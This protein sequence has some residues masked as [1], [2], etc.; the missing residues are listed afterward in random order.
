MLLSIKSS[1]QDLGYILAKNPN[2]LPIAKNE[3]NGLLFGFFDNRPDI[4]R[5][6]YLEQETLRDDGYL[7][8]EKYV[9]PRLA[10]AIFSKILNS[11][12]SKDMLQ[13][14]DHQ[15]Y[16]QLNY[17]K[18]PKYLI[19]S[20]SAA[21][22]TFEA[23]EKT[24]NVYS[25]IFSSH[26][27][28]KDALN[29]VFF[30]VQLAYSDCEDFTKDQATKLMKYFAM[31]DPG[32]T[33]RRSVKTCLIRTGQIE[34]HISELNKTKHDIRMS[35]FNSQE[36]RKAFA[37]ACLAKSEKVNIVDIGCGSGYYL[38]ALK[39]QIESYQGVDTNDRCLAK[40]VDKA[41]YLGITANVSVLSDYLD[42]DYSDQTIVLLSESIEHV[43][44]PE[45]LLSFV[46]EKR[47]AQI[48]ITT[49]NKQF[50]KYLLIEGFRQ[51]DHLR[52]YDVIEFEA[53]VSK[54]FSEHYEIKMVG[55][56]DYCE[57]HFIT[58]GAHLVRKEATK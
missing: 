27:K 16:V 14:T 38:A 43:E 48:I 39:R 13:D 54:V 37:R 41:K 58:Q 49:P 31:S 4:Y 53:L 15:H 42:A 22:P 1:N 25:I 26:G 34:A 36:A 30:I 3:G 10:N 12:L 47:P 55:I 44:E 40:V 2:S 20:Y 9:A 6:A 29:A 5:V 46:N 52:E 7:T 23:I 51:E 50:N 35:P 57:G 33:I 45:E 11:A 19:E 24:K 56:G 21:Y 17:L 32:Y 8:T 28:L 18:C